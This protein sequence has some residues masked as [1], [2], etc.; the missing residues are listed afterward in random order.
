LCQVAH[1]DPNA[2][3]EIGKYSPLHWAASNGHDSVVEYLVSQ[4]NCN[5][6]LTTIVNSSL[7]FAVCSDEFFLVRRNCSRY[8][9]SYEE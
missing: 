1:F 6:Q 5:P 3:E 8:C 2:Q 7:A 9:F 4:A